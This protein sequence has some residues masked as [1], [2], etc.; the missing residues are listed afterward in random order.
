MI[1]AILSHIGELFHN[2]QAGWFRPA[3][4]FTLIFGH[5]IFETVRWKLYGP[6][7]FTKFL[8]TFY[9][10]IYRTVVPDISSFSRCVQT[11]IMFCMQALFF[12]ISSYLIYEPYH[13]MFYDHFLRN[14]YIF[15]GFVMLLYLVNIGLNWY[16]RKMKAE[17]V[18]FDAR[19]I[20][21]VHGGQDT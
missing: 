9:A 12:Y 15:L 18:I 2:E 1:G 20:F 6:E 14:N 10:G 17:P 4:L 19:N 16:F 3:I 13:W 8:Y 21:T 5:W 7:G 11:N